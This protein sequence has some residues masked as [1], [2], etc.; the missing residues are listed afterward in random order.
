[1]IHRLFVDS[2]VRLNR[3]FVRRAGT[4]RV[5]SVDFAYN[6]GA[7]R[8]KINEWVSQETHGLIPT[9]G[10][11]RRITGAT[12]MALVNALYFKGKWWYQFDP[13]MTE[14]GI[15]HGVN[16]DQNVSYMT[17]HGR[18]LNYKEVPEL[19]GVMFQLPY[20]EK[21]FDLHV[22]LPNEVD[23]WRQAEQAYPVYA[24]EIFKTSFSATFFKQLKLPKWEI[25]F[26][27]E[28]LDDGLKSLGIT[29]VFT[30]DSNLSAMTK[31]DQLQLSTVIHKAKFI[32]DEEVSLLALFDT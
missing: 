3:N 32:V 15:F 24:E 27:F 30:Q 22:F 31:N 21:D 13:N 23:G 8:N 2:S 26:T 19:G 9:L 29:D 6:S 1:M 7:V 14:T 28:G 5:V 10:S 12:I 16:G 4:N 17:L 18:F 20:E 11:K 25:D